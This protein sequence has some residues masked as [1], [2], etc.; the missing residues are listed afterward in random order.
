MSKFLKIFLLT[1]IFILLAFQFSFATEPTGE[2]L[3]QQMEQTELMSENSI[4]E[5]ATTADSNNALSDT[6]TN[7]LDNSLNN[8][9]NTSVDTNTTN[10]EN[11][12]NTNEEETSSTSSSLS[13]GSQVTGVSNR[14]SL[15]EANLGLNN[16]LSI[17]LIAIGFLLILFA[18]AILIRLKK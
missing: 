18:I 1:T 3:T 16:I 14:S 9:L 7:N 13:S 8:A 12:S 4:G 17:L 11:T 5:P 15:P 10:T 2:M 6:S